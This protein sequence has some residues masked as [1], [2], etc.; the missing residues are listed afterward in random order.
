MSVT[1]AR[2]HEPELLLDRIQI[3][4]R[5]QVELRDKHGRIKATRDVRNLITTVGRNWI[6]EQILAA[7]TAATK[8]ITMT[9]GT[10][11]TAATVADTTITTAGLTNAAKALTSKTRATN[12]LTMV[13]NWAAGDATGSLQEAGCFDGQGTPQLHSRATYTTIPKGASD[14]LQITWTWT[15]G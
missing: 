7:P 15:I 4:G 13:A 11:G 2:A 14:T 9:V 3:V 10:S 12:V 6:V 8:P 1:E 5:V